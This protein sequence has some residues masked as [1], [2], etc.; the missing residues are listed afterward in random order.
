M[1]DKPP[2]LNPNI[3][4]SWA[5]EVPVVYTDVE[6][7]LRRSFEIS[8]GFI[9]KISVLDAGS[10]AVAA[11]V[12][13]AIT[14][15]SDLSP[16]QLRQIVDGLVLIVIL[17]LISLVFTVVHHFLAVRIAKLEAMY[18]E[19]DFYR[20]MIWSCVASI[21][22]VVSENE[23]VKIDELMKEL[24]VE[25]IKNQEK[26]VKKKKLLHKWADIIGNASIC[27]FLVAY[28]IVTF[29]VFKLW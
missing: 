19:I 26:I 7:E 11:S 27:L 16:C 14:T 5:A 8:T 21:R 3:F 9:D 17:F 22:D 28:I 18:S 29:Y 10:I 1:C 12:I 15:R 23:K 25:P 4:D 20:K 24:D 2:D 6:K 13:I